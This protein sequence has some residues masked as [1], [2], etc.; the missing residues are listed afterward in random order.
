[1]QTTFATL[2]GRAG[3]QTLIQK[4]ALV[5]LGSVLLAVSA[6]VQ[7]PFWP[8]PMTM[9]T[10]VVLLIGAHAGTR[11]AGATVFAYL[12]EGAVGLPVF[13]TGAGLAFMAGPT[14]GY[15]VGFLLSAIMVSFAFER[16]LARTLPK[17][18]AVF[19]AGD[20][21][22]LGLGVAWLSTLIGFEK[23]L[24]VGVVPFLPAA[25]LKIALAAASLPLVSRFTAR[26]TDQTA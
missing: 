2:F 26:D 5:L 25:A 3:E 14:G 13:S 6:K 21:V 23:A 8:V 18:L 20:L 16:G 11:L 4:A 10:L 19:V 12:L 9:Q 24:M 22:I 17:A 15:L 7:V 1:M